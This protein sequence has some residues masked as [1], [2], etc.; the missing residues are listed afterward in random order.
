MGTVS[1]CGNRPDSLSPKTPPGLATDQ[2]KV[3]FRTAMNGITLLSLVIS[4]TISSCRPSWM[5]VG[6]DSTR[7]CRTE[8]HENYLSTILSLRTLIIY[9][10]YLLRILDSGGGF[11]ERLEHQGHGR[12]QF[13]PQRLFGDGWTGQSV[14]SQKGQQKE[15]YRH[16][17][18]IIFEITKEK[19]NIL[20]F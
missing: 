8:Q 6:S 16:C 5:L 3:C 19:R 20:K 4:V 14:G 18:V 13:T 7:S 2:S 1:M 10:F 17:L 9:Y 15:R 11:M 12:S